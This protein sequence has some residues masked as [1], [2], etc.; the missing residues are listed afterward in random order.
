[1]V[2]LAAGLLALTILTVRPALA[3]S[4]PPAVL[5]TQCSACHGPNGA[6]PGAIPSINQLD[7]EGMTASLKS[8]KSG[9]TQGTVMNRIAKGYSDEEIA[10]LSQY[11]STLK[12]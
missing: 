7:A 10:A 12:R 8:F 11:F 2:R 4:A 3:D 6:S 5:A 9:E 1:M